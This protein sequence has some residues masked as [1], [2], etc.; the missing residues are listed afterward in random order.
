M[1][2][3]VTLSSA[4]GT[5]VAALFAKMYRVI[6]CRNVLATQQFPILHSSYVAAGVLSA[7]GDAKHLEDLCSEPHSERQVAPGCVG[8]VA[9]A[10]S[11]AA[12]VTTPSKKSVRRVREQVLSFVCADPPRL[13]QPLYGQSKRLQ[14]LYA[15]VFDSQ[16]SC[17]QTVKARIN[18]FDRGEWGLASPAALG[19]RPPVPGR[20]DCSA[21]TFDSGIAS[22]H[23]R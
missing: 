21:D 23:L 19:K 13:R 16:S 10:G 12:L 14:R 7:A 11:R 8:V 15:N 22:P 17:E 9:A 20:I 6:L 1:H 4:S 2:H 5:R 18:M 3:Y